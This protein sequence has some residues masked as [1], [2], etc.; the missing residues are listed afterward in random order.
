MYLNIINSDSLNHASLRV[1][2]E[3]NKVIHVSIHFANN[4]QTDQEKQDF[5][6]SKKTSVL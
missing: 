4:C 3:N 6:V 1:D 2:I 5:G